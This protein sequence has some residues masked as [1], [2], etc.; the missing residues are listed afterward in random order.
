MHLGELTVSVQQPATP[1]GKPPVLLIHGM[2]GGAWYWEGYQRFLAQRG[3]ASH[4]V[5]LRGHHGSRPVADL[6]RVR[7]GDYVDDAVTV[8]RSLGNPIV[9]GHSMGGLIAQKVAEAAACRTLVL[10]AAAPP[11]GIPVVTWQLLKRQL[12][13]IAPMVRSEV[14]YP[15]RKDADALMFNRTPVAD[16]DAFF[17]RLVGESGRAALE[18]SLGLVGVHATRVTAPVLVVTGRDDLMVAPRVAGALARKYGAPLK[19]FDSFGH[20]IMSEPGWEQPAEAIVTW[21]DTVAHA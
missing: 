13:L 19:A 8:A 2:F 11:R 21:V 12:P 4:A 6:G 3:Y 1:T 14:I 17:S 18:M 9:I 10:M 5:N 16:R 7:I 20:H 15:R